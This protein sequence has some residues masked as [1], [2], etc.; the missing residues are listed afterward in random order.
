[1]AIPLHAFVTT[2]IDTRSRPESIPGGGQATTGLTAN[3]L[4]CREWVVRPSHLVG[5]TGAYCGATTAC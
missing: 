4:D 2:R 1:M 5:N 3:T